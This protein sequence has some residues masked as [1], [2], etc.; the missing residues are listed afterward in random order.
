VALSNIDQRHRSWHKKLPSQLPLINGAHPL[1]Q[2]LCTSV[3]N[4]CLVGLGQPVP[5][6]I[7]ET[8]Q[9]KDG[10]EESFLQTE[11]S[12]FPLVSSSRS[13]LLLL[14]GRRRRCY[15][16]LRAFV[17]SLS[18]EARWPARPTLRPPHCKTKAY[19]EVSPSHVST[20]PRDPYGIRP[21]VTGPAQRSVLRTWFVIAFL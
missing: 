5:P 10:I 2:P 20:R 15:P 18:S 3:R 7:N 13:S 16:S 21:T 11:L 17:T 19:D 8:E 14:L 6:A 9:A 4:G 1:F 12:T